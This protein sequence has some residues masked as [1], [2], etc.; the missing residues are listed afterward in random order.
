MTDES[1]ES[2]DGRGIEKTPMDTPCGRVHRTFSRV[3]GESVTYR[4]TLKRDTDAGRPAYV[5][6]VE[7]LT[8]GL[9]ASIRDAGSGAFETVAVSRTVGPYS[10][11]MVAIDETEQQIVDYEAWLDEFEENDTLWLSSITVESVKADLNEATQ[12]LEKLRD[13]QQRTVNTFVY[14]VSFEPKSTETI[15]AIGSEFDRL[16]TLDGIAAVE[17]E[18]ETPAEDPRNF[19][20]F[21]STRDQ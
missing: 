6:R 5:N 3:S 20:G 10:R 18:N 11:T 17:I 15:N 9:E 8:E 1:T 2:F 14:T 13:D 7:S 12:S 21:R 19:I 4:I 16:G